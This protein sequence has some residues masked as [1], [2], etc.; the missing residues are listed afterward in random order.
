MKRIKG[1]IWLNCQQDY[2]RHAFKIWKL[3]NFFSN[4]LLHL[5]QLV[6]PLSRYWKSQNICLFWKVTKSNQIEPHVPINWD[7]LHEKIE[8]SHSLSANNPSLYTYMT[9]IRKNEKETWRILALIDRYRIS[10]NTQRNK[11]VITYQN[12]CTINLSNLVQPSM[13]CT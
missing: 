9:R 2:L 3:V 1:C 10:I 4:T 13:Q 5:F 11:I 6:C 7:G 12:D 8:N